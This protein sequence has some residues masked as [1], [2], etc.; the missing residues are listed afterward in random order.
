MCRDRVS[1]FTVTHSGRVP[2]E[3]QLN[4]GKKVLGSMAAARGCSSGWMVASSSALGR[5]KS[6]SVPGP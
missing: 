4:G 2:I 6:Q 5:G 3:S 1:N